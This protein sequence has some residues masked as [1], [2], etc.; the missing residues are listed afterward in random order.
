MFNKT[1]KRIART[2]RENLFNP[3]QSFSPQPWHVPGEN[4]F[5]VTQTP[6]L[7]KLPRL[8]FTLGP[9]ESDLRNRLEAFE[10]QPEQIT[11]TQ[12]IIPGNH[13]FALTYTLQEKPLKPIIE[14]EAHNSGGSEQILAETDDFTV[15]YNTG[16]IT[17]REAVDTIA[18]LAVTY[19]TGRVAGPAASVC[20]TQC[21]SIEVTATGSMDAEAVAAITIGVIE[22]FKEEMLGQPDKTYDGLNV[23]TFLKPIDIQLVNKAEDAIAAD[24]ASVTLNYQVPGIMR[25]ARKVQEEDLSVIEKIFHPDVEREYDEQDVVIK[26]NIPDEG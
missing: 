16:Q 10:N 6:D 19:R 9:L 25:I 12:E 24:R 8:V 17:F 13:G 15:D 20:L 11:L 3:D 26:A 21:F 5:N 14:V 1:L 7:E 4:V 22:A 18:G 23:V 2:V